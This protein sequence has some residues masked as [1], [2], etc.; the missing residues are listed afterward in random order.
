MTATKPL[1][2]CEQ[3]GSIHKVPTNPK[4]LNNKKNNNNDSNKTLVLKT[5]WAVRFYSQSA[6]KPKTTEQQEEQQ[7]NPCLEDNVSSEVLFIKCQQTQN[8]R[9]TTRAT[10]MIATKPL[11]WRQC[12]QWGSIHK[13]P[14]NPKQPNS[15]KNNNNYSNK[16]LVLKIMWA[17]RFYS[18]T[19]L[20]FELYSSSYIHW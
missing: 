12:E 10:T 20:D 15:N 18:Q 19:V 2:Q 4:Q 1:R 7:Q 11:S 16:T 8:N 3:W 14:T 5:M 17:V 6:N 9:T 13:V